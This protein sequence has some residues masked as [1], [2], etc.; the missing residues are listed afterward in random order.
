MRIDGK[1][2]LS[3]S[4]TFN[5]EV[6][7]EAHLALLGALSEDLVVNGLATVDLQLEGTP[8]APQL[9]GEARFADVDGSWR[10]IEWSGL[11]L[12]VSSADGRLRLDSLAGEVMGA[13][14]TA[15]G[16]LPFARSPDE[17]WRLEVEI[18]S[19][20]PPCS[21]EGDSVDLADLAGALENT[22]LR[23][24]AS[25]KFEGIG[26]D[27]DSIT[28]SGTAALIGRHA[29]H[30]FATDG[31][32]A[33]QLENR[34]LTMS[35]MNLVGEVA[36]ARIDA[37][38]VLASDGIELD[39]TVAGHFEL[40][41]LGEL[42]RRSGFGDVEG[43]VEIAVDLSRRGGAWSWNGTAQLDGGELALLRPRILATAV[44][45][46]IAFEDDRVRLDSF[47]G[48][49]GGGAFDGRRRPR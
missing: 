37:A 38:A 4:S 19:V 35:E 42:L 28:G 39:A 20:S 12:S 43:D 33:W 46:S 11:G 8:S 16:L 23:L 29:E 27:L 17:P 30:R 14:V 47:S 9:V 49:I 5:L 18:D 1:L 36:D 24:T 32:A 48:T 44:R 10:E 41:V 3:A 6:S 7:G 15:E 22:E 25:G 40:V 31:S 13:Q 34:Q 2:A 26:F 45:A 21:P